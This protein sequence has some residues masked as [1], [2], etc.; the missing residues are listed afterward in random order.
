M[1]RFVAEGDLHVKKVTSVKVGVGVL[2]FYAILTAVMV[3]FKVKFVMFL[4]S[5]MA[6]LS[7]TTSYLIPTLYKI[8]TEKPAV[9]ED[10]QAVNDDL[11][12]DLEF[13]DPKETIKLDKQ[14]KMMQEYFTE[15]DKEGGKGTKRRR[16][17]RVSPAGSL[18]RKMLNFTLIV[19]ILCFYGLI[20]FN[21][22]YHIVK[23]YID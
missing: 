15:Y 17:Q 8:Y 2:V 14:G 16:R 13:G 11:N 6:L 12:M 4:V 22:A 19:V 18:L 1:E 20:I 7:L 5:I 9:Q 21:I 23:P 3:Y 10:N